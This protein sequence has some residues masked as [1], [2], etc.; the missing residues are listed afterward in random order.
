MVS[1]VTVGLALLAAVIVFSLAASLLRRGLVT[2]AQF[3]LILA[4]AALLLA[5]AV[6]VGVRL[7]DIRKLEGRIDPTKGIASVMIELTEIQKEVYAKAKTVE[8]LADTVGELSALNVVG[9]WRLPP[10]DPYAYRLRARDEIAAMLQRA[11]LAPA[12]V[13]AIASVITRA[14][15]ED[16]ARTAFN[17]VPQLRT[18]TTARVRFVDRLLRSRPGSAVSDLR[19]ALEDVGAWSPAVEARLREFDEFRVHGKPPA[20]PAGAL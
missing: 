2:G 9:L 10:E 8:D 13:A 20:A 6:I 1:V 5:V 15:A 17:S 16:L 11:K 12:R 4:A 19:P 3:P 14:V 7:P 18:D